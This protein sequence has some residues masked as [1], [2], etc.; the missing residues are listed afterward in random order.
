MLQEMVE[1]G[2]KFKDPSMVL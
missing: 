1:Q 2:F